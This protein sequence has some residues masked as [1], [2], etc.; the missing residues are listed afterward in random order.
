MEM[1]HHLPPVNYL[2][3]QQLHC[4]VEHESRRPAFASVIFKIAFIA[5]VASKNAVLT[6]RTTVKFVECVQLSSPST[7]I[8]TGV[9]P[10]EFPEFGCND[11]VGGIATDAYCNCEFHHYEQATSSWQ[12]K[13][14]KETL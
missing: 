7:R 13:F 2:S 8:I 10:S 11:T 9:L 14:G 12:F 6:I 4:N 1:I 5:L 3:Q